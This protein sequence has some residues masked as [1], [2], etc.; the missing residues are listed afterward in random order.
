MVQNCAPYEH[1]DAC[2]KA[3]LY[4]KP[5]EVDLKVK[6]TVKIISRDLLFSKS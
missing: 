6:G 3:S 5:I 4:V 1:L 2:V